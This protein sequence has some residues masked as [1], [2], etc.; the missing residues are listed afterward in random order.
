M[1]RSHNE[2]QHLTDNYQ[3]KQVDRLGPFKD[4]KRRPEDTFWWE[5]QGYDIYPHS[6]WESPHDQLDDSR[7]GYSRNHSTYACSCHRCRAGW[8]KSNAIEMRYKRKT[9]AQDQYFKDGVKDYHNS[10]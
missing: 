6:D 9:Y 7:M 3:R 5:L 8:T 4:Y 2:R 1:T 10:T